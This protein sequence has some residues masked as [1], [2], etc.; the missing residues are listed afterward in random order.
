M[1]ILIISFL[2]IIVGHLCAQDGTKNFIDQNY[3]EVT[4]L[5]ELKV[6][7]DLIYLKIILKEKDS[8]DKISLVELEKGML[9]SLKK[10]GVNTS[11]DLVVK[12]MSSNYSYYVLN[13]DKIHMTKAY[14]LLVY[15]VKTVDKVFD[16][17]KEIGISNISIEKL[18]NSKISEYKKQ[19]KLNAISAAREKAEFLTDAIDQQIGRA[20]YIQEKENRI[21]QS[22]L[23][24]STTRGKSTSN[25]YYLL[26]SDN[27]ASAFE[28][29]ILEY[30]VL[31]RFILK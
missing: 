11:E 28:N 4:G 30:S 26:A 16:K 6:V 22:I 12:D 19:V 23:P 17:L 27:E 31:C 7:P 14:Q 9:E 8:K 21:Y 2:L 25:S 15:D 10:L 3:I 29:I 20:I 13:K 24:Q 1:R 18:D 5:A